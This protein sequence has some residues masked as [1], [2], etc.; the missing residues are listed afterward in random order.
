MRLNWQNAARVIIRMRQI[1]SVITSG[2]GEQ[3]ASTAQQVNLTILDRVRN[4]QDK[5]I[6]CAIPLG[7]NKAN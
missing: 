5:R 3:M 7:E 4:V 1:F 6:A 2:N